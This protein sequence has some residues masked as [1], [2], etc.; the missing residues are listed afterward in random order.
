[1]Y[2]IIHCDHRPFLPL[3]RMQRVVELDI[4]IKQFI[5]V[6]KNLCTICVRCILQDLFVPV[7]EQ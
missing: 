3:K 6:K 5:L 2:L 1:M 7:F 4:C